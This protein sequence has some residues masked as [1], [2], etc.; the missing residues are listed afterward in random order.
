MS[1]TPRLNDITL[2]VLDI[3]I[4]G[5]KVAHNQATLSSLFKTL[6]YYSVAKTI[7]HEL[8][9]KKYIAWYCAMG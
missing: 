4:S 6:Y 8:R 5:Y 9:P 3:A 1:I 7:I 2:R